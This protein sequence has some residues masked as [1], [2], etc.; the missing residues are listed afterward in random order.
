MDQK[1]VSKLVGFEN[2]LRQTLGVEIEFTENNTII[3][4]SLGDY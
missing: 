4:V 2:Y 1:I 3:N